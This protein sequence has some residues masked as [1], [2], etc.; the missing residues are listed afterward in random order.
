MNTTRNLCVGHRFVSREARARH[1]S[2]IRYVKSSEDAFGMFAYSRQNVASLAAHIRCAAKAESWGF[3]FSMVLPL[4][5]LVLAHH[6][7]STYFE[8]KRDQTLLKWT[9]LSAKF[10]DSKLGYWFSTVHAFNIDLFT[11]GT[12]S[13]SEP[14]CTRGLPIFFQMPGEKCVL[15][16]KSGFQWVIRHKKRSVH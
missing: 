2:A 5:R 6:F 15:I 13:W 1:P 4:A 14:Y 3:T 12:N 7:C 8:T 16:P 11:Q 9:K 10:V